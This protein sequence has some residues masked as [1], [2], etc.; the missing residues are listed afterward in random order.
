VKDRSHPAI[1]PTLAPRLR[2]F[3]DKHLLDKPVEVSEDAVE[4]GKKILPVSYR[5][6][7]W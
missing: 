6:A 3:F 5:K 4:V 7:N 1:S 2:A